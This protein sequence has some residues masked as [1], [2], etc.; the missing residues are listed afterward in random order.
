MGA[1]TKDAIE[2]FLKEYSEKYGNLEKNE[3]KMLNKHISSL[4]AVVIKKTHMS[5]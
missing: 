1:L 5:A 2:D 4:S 3:Q